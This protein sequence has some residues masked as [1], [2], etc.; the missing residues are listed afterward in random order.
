MHYLDYFLLV[1]SKLALLRR[2]GGDAVAAL[3]QA[4]FLISLE[5][6]VDTP[7]RPANMPMLATSVVADSV[8]KLRVPDSNKA[9]HTAGT[10][11][12]RKSG[13]GQNSQ[14]TRRKWKKTHGS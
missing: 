3:I 10:V 6:A 14:E 11:T 13:A 12:Q 5:T 2:T 4:G 7:G 8:S 1:S 9:Q